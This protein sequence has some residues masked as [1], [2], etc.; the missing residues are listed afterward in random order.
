MCLKNNRKKKMDYRTLVNKLEAIENGATLESASKIPNPYKDP[1]QAAKF[2]AMSD[3]D[4]EWL[5]RGGG[6][7]NIDD[8]IILS[9]APNKGKPDPKKV[10]AAT[11]AAGSGQGAKPAGP[12]GDEFIKANLAKL[13]ELVA[14]LEATR[15]PM[16]S[17][18]Y[19]IANELV[20]SFGYQTDE[21]AAAGM[22]KA[23]LS[24]AGKTFARAMPGV[25]LALGAKDAYDRFQ[26][27]DYTGAG[28]AGLSGITSLVPGLGTAATLGLSAANLARDYKR[29]EFD[30]PAAA[31]ATPPA[32]GQ[33][34]KPQQGAVNLGIAQM[35]KELGVDADGMIG[36]MTKAA[37]AKNPKL[38]AKYG[39]GPDGNPLPKKESVAESIASLRDRLAM[40]EASD[41]EK[42]EI[43]DND[44][45]KESDNQ[46]DEGVWGSLAN[47]GKNFA[48][49][50]RGGGTVQP[51]VKGARGGEYAGKVA[52]GGIAARK[53]GT[54]INK[55]P[56]KTALGAT[57]LGAGAGLA[58]GGS[59]AAAKPDRTA[60]GS[61]SGGGSS[62]PTPASPNSMS[63]DQQELINQIQATM[64]TLADVE[65]PAVV[66][67][68][69]TAQAAISR[70]GDNKPQSAMDNA[71]AAAAQAAVAG[72]TA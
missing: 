34:A 18:D 38:A 20:E 13:A 10:A 43:I 3:V 14:K 53:L 41:K 70:F 72:R 2:D 46:Q 37:M 47:V 68:L 67:G 19:N 62:T 64:A 71:T 35:Q 9:R 1:A 58:L 16:E 36:P 65:D 40:I 27:G 5:T 7:P 28:I 61:S 66:S 22:G 59:G 48:S 33:G 63:P 60:G 50:L 54:A 57:A 42:D 29:G 6:V 32:A 44:E 15:K 56:V 11:P 31:T 55:N 26:K 12:R 23:A 45:D 24:G 4:Q 25:G 69:Q 49:G 8:E 21:N 39:F 30:D 51:M 52:P 17:T